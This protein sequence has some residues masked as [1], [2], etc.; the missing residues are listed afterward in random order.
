M[1]SHYF[2]AL[3]SLPQRLPQT[4]GSENKESCIGP[5]PPPGQSWEGSGTST[6]PSPRISKAGM[7]VLCNDIECAVT[8]PPVHRWTAI[9]AFGS[10]ATPWRGFGVGRYR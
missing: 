7:L 9:H 2:F 3:G 5:V 1:L 8:W 6:T 4:E 10:H